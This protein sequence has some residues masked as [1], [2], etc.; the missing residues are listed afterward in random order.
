MSGGI[1]ISY[2]RDDSAGFAGR[3]YDRI[4]SRLNRER[5]FF[6]VDNIELGVDFVQVLSD[7]VADCDALV[8]IIGRDWLTAIDEDGRRR[9]DNP[10]DFVRIELAAALQRDIPVIPILVGGAV[11]PR[12][13]MLPEALKP[14][15]RRQGLAI[16]H[17][18]FDSDS[19]RL[20]KAL[21]F[22]EEA[23]RKRER[24]GEPKVSQRE[25]A[26]TA[27]RAEDVRDKA[28]VDAA[29]R[30]EEMRRRRDIA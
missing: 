25:E 12:Q 24:A 17:E 28:G 30:V 14:L 26:E 23:R 29:Q 11:M 20:T 22:V 19:E 27:K 21:A 18:R 4:A 8:A 1:F 6:D 10:K 5:V 9:L 2:R 13:E 3:I 15:V 16:S 7:R